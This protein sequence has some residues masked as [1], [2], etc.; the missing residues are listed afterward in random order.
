MACCG[1]QHMLSL[2]KAGQSEVV[3]YDDESRIRL[4]GSGVGWILVTEVTEP[5]EDG[6]ESF[7]GHVHLDGLSRAWPELSLAMRP[8]A[9][10][11][12]DQMARTREHLD[13]ILPDRGRAVLA[14]G[15]DWAV[16]LSAMSSFDGTLLVEWHQSRPLRGDEF[17]AALRVLARW[18]DRVEVE[19]C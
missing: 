3:W 12:P 11:A 16:E 15:D 9:D 19:A 4:D 17:L 14:A 2:P 18:L 13:A 1:R 6:V 10:F 5:G 8:F 7:P